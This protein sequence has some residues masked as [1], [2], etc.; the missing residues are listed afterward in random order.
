MREPVRG[1]KKRTEAQLGGRERGLRE[2]WIT[3]LKARLPTS[4]S[5][6]HQRMQ[7][8]PSARPSTHHSPPAVAAPA[9]RRAV[10]RRPQLAASASE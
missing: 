8:V 7:C 9:R 2:C 10:V 4:A 5:G 3:C 6:L 1:K